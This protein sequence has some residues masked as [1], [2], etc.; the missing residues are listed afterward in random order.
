MSFSLENVKAV[1]GTVSPTFEEYFGR[2][3]FFEGKPALPESVGYFVVL[4]FGAFFSIT[5]TILVYLNKKY[6][7]LQTITSEHFKYVFFTSCGVMF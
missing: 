7:K 6:G 1:A 5:T 2:E 4:G 3:S